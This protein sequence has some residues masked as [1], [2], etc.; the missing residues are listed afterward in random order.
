M[1]EKKKV[2][3]RRSFLGPDG[4]TS[5]YIAAPTSDDIRGAD[6]EYSKMFTRCLMEGITTA[7]EMLDLLR[8]RGIIGPE[9]EQR[10]AELSE[11]LTKKTL[12]LE[13][14]KSMEEKRELAIEVAAAREELFQ[15]NQRQAGP[16]NNTSEQISDDVRLEYL[17][18]CMIETED[19][20]RV[21]NSYD[22]Y[23]T[24]Q[25]QALAV[26]ARFEVML[27][28]QGLDSDFL[29]QTP[30]AQA[31]REIESDILKQAEEA[32]KTIEQLEKEEEEKK[33]EESK[34]KT[35]PKTTKKRTAKKK[36]K[37]E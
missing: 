3:E 28:L 31:M 15:W 24:E 5:Y 35:K 23:L 36:P 6:W 29:E 37:D 17:T 19:G 26:R 27:F 18:A 9:F 32:L 16:M 30:E 11:E 22:E 8:R 1:A 14:A 12:A 34:K 7:A 10:S 25:S 21:W 13:N 20:K 2:D 33:K 4:I